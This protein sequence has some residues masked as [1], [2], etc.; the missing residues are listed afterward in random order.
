MTSKGVVATPVT[1]PA[2][3]PAQ[4]HTQKILEACANHMVRTGFFKFSEAGLS[5]CED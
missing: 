5:L 3:A 4:L 1:D 2:I